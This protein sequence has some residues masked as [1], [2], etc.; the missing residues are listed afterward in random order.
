MARRDDRA[1]RE[2]V[3]EEQ[4]RQSGCP[5]RESCDASRFQGT[6]IPAAVP[7]WRGS[8][9]TSPVATRRGVLSGRALRLRDNQPSPNA[10]P[11]RR[12]DCRVLLHATPSSGQGGSVGKGWLLS[13]AS[14]TSATAE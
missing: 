11:G 13:A 1:Y 12:L 10:G 2:Y 9:K 4:R 3:R 14:I 5:A 6:S 8:P 7:R